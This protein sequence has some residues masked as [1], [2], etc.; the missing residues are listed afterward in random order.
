VC[1][2]NRRAPGRLVRGPM[3]TVGITL[4]RSP[5]PPLAIL[6]SIDVRWDA[7][8]RG[9]EGRRSTARRQGGK[10]KTA[11]GPRPTHSITSPIGID[12]AVLD[13]FEGLSGSMMRSAAFSGSAKR[14]SVAYF[15][16]R[17]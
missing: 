2:P 3:V 4:S 17:R 6:D 7:C 1:R 5:C 15:I 11:Q 13:G 14:R 8:V 10:R 16:G 9:G 12:P